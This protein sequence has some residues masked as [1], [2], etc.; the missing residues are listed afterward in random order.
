MSRKSAQE[1]PERRSSPRTALDVDVEVKISGRTHSMQVLDASESGMLLCAPL[2]PIHVERFQE[3][4]VV[5][6]SA[7]NIPAIPATV[8][9]VV[10]QEHAG[11]D[12]DFLSGFA[13]KLES[14]ADLSS[15][16]NM[17]EGALPAPSDVTPT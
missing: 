6:H 7:A 17:I 16:R 1:P 11:G 5:L 10:D 2:R 9:R 13:V 15:Y 3:V 4:E 8:I 14:S 12:E